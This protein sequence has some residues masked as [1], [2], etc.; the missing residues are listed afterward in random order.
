MSDESFYAVDVGDLFRV[1]SNL[2]GFH[3]WQVTGIHLGIVGRMDAVTLRSLDENSPVVHGT[4]LSEL[5]VPL[6]LLA[7]A[8]L[9]RIN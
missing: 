2:G 4:V 6:S 5:V 9:E 8:S 7:V 3:V 1:P